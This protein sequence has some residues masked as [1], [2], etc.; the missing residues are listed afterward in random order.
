MLT[1]ID[2]AQKIHTLEERL[3]DPEVRAD[4]NLVSE[5][6]ADDFYEIG[7]SGNTF[8]KTATVQSLSNEIEQFSKWTISD[9]TM[10]LLGP[11]IVQVRYRIPESSTLRSSLW[12]KENDGWVIFFH[13][14]TFANYHDAMRPLLHV[15]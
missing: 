8:D 6:L 3:L 7:A 4:S 5:L 2:L 15:S 9:F 1:D 14:G 10:I 11:K 13:Q 12:R